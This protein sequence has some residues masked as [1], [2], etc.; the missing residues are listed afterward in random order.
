MIFI[1]KMDHL[2]KHKKFL[3][4]LVNIPQRAIP[5]VLKHASRDQIKVL[6]EIAHNRHSLPITSQQLKELQ[7]HKQY[8]NQLDLCCSTA[9]TV[10]LTKAKQI[11]SKVQTGGALP[12]LLLPLLPLI[13]KAIFA[14]AV[15]AGTGLAV[16]ALAN[17]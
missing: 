14:G 16:K 6:I 3:T 4:A 5:Q 8:Y 7:Q 11:L 13:G 9:K 15:S 12:L 1:F 2:N 17:K 10:N